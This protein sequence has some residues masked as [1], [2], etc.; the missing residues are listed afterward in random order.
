M[1]SGCLFPTY[2]F[3]FLLNLVLFSFPWIYTSLNKRITFL[4]FPHFITLY[5]DTPIIK[6]ALQKYM[7]SNSFF[8]LFGMDFH[9]QIALALGKH[10]T[11]IG[12]RDWHADNILNQC[13][14]GHATQDNCDS[15]YWSPAFYTTC[16]ISVSQR[17]RDTWAA[18]I[19]F[20]QGQYKK[21]WCVTL[22]IQNTN[23]YKP[24]LKILVSIKPWQFNSILF[25]KH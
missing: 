21:N 12:A 5:H 20:F 7:K 19:C 17:S 13:T 11:L 8:T 16:K 25:I 3:N 23:T 4:L 24:R 15:S 18:P 22:L 9:E 2:L 6:H 1:Y 14:D 10:L